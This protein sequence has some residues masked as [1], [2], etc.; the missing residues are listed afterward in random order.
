MTRIGLEQST[1]NFKRCR[2][3]YHYTKTLFREFEVALQSFAGFGPFVS[4]WHCLL[5]L[6][7]RKS[8]QRHLSCGLS[9]SGA[10]AG[11]F[12]RGVEA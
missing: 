6:L 8:T 3:A 12:A 4:H 9:F 11:L 10:A 5:P 1:C 7:E 2:E